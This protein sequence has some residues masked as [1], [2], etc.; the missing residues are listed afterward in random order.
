MGMFPKTVLKWTPLPVGKNK[1]QNRE[2]KN[3]EERGD[4][5]KKPEA[6]NG[7]GP[8]S[9]RELRGTHEYR[10]FPGGRP[11]FLSWAS[12]DR[13]ANALDDFGKEPVLHGNEAL[14]DPEILLRDK[15]HQDA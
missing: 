5:K 4:V 15:H 8:E 1:A 12:L 9:V 7:E 10:S 13:T 6:P 3:G 14:P 2:N 11:M